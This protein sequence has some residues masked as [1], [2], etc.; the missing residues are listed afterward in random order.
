MPSECPK[1]FA[2]FGWLSLF[3]RPAVSGPVAL[4]ATDMNLTNQKGLIRQ[5]KSDHEREGS[6]QPL[7]RLTVERVRLWLDAF[8]PPGRPLTARASGSKE[9]WRNCGPAGIGSCATSGSLVLMGGFRPCGE[10][11]GML[12]PPFNQTSLAG[13]WAAIIL[14][15]AHAERG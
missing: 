1:G 15:R 9:R 8:G 10:G 5:S 2:A 7:G 6:V 3:V 13:C 14:G 4:D 12:L 11:L